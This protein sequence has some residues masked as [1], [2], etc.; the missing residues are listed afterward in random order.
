MT[1]KLYVV[2]EEVPDSVPVIV[3]DPAPVFKDNPPGK[4]PDVIANDTAFVAEI[5]IVPT[6]APAL[7]VPSVPA[8][9]VQPGT[10]D[11][12]SKAD[13]VRTALPSLFSSLIKYVP[14]T[15]KVKFAVTDVA[16]EKLTELAAMLEPV[17]FIAST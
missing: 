10:S 16:L 7:K 2:V 1:V 12:V 11:T 17:E 3:A 14:S 9:V 13:P 5:V 8:L 6:L 4:A 15:G